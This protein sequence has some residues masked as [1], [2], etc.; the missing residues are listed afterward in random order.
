LKTVSDPRPFWASVNGREDEG[1]DGGNATVSSPFFFF[2][3]QTQL[4]QMENEVRFKTKSHLT[5]PP[6]KND[7]Y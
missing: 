6:V 7:D 4:I 5:P 1:E 2:Y 3:L